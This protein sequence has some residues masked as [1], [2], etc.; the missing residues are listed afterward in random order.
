MDA[1]ASSHGPASLGIDHLDDLSQEVGWR[2]YPGT[3]ESGHFGPVRR[4]RRQILDCRG[5]PG[6]H[7]NPRSGHVVVTAG[8]EH[9]EMSENR[10]HASRHPGRRLLPT[11]APRGID[12]L[13]VT[14][15][16]TW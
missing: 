1:L 4:G 13:A 6:C 11:D 12:H 9:R 5:C 14:H 2:T 15:R 8:F 3:P 10:Y 16:S 7:G